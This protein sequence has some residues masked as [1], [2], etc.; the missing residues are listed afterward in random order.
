MSRYTRRLALVVGA[1][2]AAVL[3]AGLGD[4]LGVA[5]ADT[6]SSPSAS[7][8]ADDGKLVLRIGTTQDAD[9]LNPFIGYST[10]SYE[11]FHL[12]YNLLVGYA[13]N[14]DPS[15]EL[16]TSWTQ[17]DDGLTWTFKTREGVTWQDGVAFTAKDDRIIGTRF[18][19]GQQAEEGS[20]GHFRRG[21]HPGRVEKGW[22]EIHEADEVVRRAA[23]LHPLAPANRQRYAHTVLVQV[24]LGARKRHAVVARHHDNGVFQFA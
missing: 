8:S 5:V 9:N 13:A 11:V 12:N 20:A 7:S 21:R 1:M 4:G 2:V 24:C 14:G 17:S 19:R 6:S 15:P 3:V 18:P 23:G 22:R 10:T 16:A